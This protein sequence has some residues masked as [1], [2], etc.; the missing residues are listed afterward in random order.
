MAKKCRCPKKTCAKRKG[1]SRF[2]PACKTEFRNCMRNEV[3]E[4]GKT[5][6]QIGS[7]C[8]PRLHQCA[9]TRGKRR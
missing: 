9:R 6:K 4:G 7:I 2:S 5:M 8:M 3:R 1:S